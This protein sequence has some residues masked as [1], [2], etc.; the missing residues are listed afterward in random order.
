MKLSA[1]ITAIAAFF[2]ATEACKCGSNVDAT[3]ACCRSVGG[4][5]TNDDCPASGI[6]E[7]LSNF[8]SCCNSLGARSD[9][10]CPV[11]CARVETDAQRL[12]AGQD[13]LTDEELAAYVNSYQD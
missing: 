8:A 10:R 6:S 5:P 2:S 1:A 7:R 13:P 12:A 3:R 4:N 11:G 9:C